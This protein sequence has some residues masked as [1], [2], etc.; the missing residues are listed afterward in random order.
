MTMKILAGWKTSYPIYKIQ[1]ESIPVRQFSLIQEKHQQ[2]INAQ[3]DY[4]GGVI[5]VGD[6]SFQVSELPDAPSKKS[7]MCIGRVR[8]R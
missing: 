2:A 8:R 3:P 7:R 6:Y 5:V 4:S 1:L